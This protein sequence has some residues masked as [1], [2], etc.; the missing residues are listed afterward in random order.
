MVKGVINIKKVTILS[1]ILML[2]TIFGFVSKPAFAQTAI[3]NGPTSPFS[4]QA[5]PGKM[6][7]TIDI[8]WFDDGRPG[9]FDLV[10]GTDPNHYTFGVIGLPDMKNQTNTFTVGALTPGTTYFF[11]LM[12]QTGGNPFIS[13]PISARATIMVAP[14]P[15]IDP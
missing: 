12:G 2:F 1:A 13:G 8:A 10:Y 7:G 14:T 15:S 4:F 11:S 6:P 5:M 9:R 3:T